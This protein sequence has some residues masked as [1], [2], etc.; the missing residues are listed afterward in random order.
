MAHAVIA[1]FDD[2][3]MINV[4]KKHPAAL[5]LLLTNECNYSFSIAYSVIFKVCLLN[6]AQELNE[7]YYRLLRS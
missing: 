4:L 6:G 2:T 3:N 7:C 5:R 1:L